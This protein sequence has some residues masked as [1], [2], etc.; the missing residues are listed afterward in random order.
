MGSTCPP[1][2]ESIR[3]FLV[4]EHALV[5]AGLRMLIESGP[6]MMVIGEAGNCAD[7]LPIVVAEQPDI[8]LLEADF[9]DQSD[10]DSV[11]K[12]ITAAKATRV[13]ILSSEQHPEMHQRA[14]QVG[15]TGLVLKDTM[16]GVLFKAIERVNAG[17]VWF[18]RALMA[19][20]LSKLSQQNGAK[21]KDV[22]QV[23]IA[24]LTQREHEVVA[25]V[26]EGLKNKQ[27]AERLFIS[28]TTVHH[29]LTSIFAKLG[30]S[31]RLELV[32]YAYQQGMVKLLKRNGDQ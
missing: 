18:E 13:I 30:V 7:A 6:A 25:L 27:I 9:G 19:D 28:D 23:R 15:A 21:G 14:M 16:P 32:I 17:E 29:H 10:L 24:T 26:G 22:E 8:V 31:D 2:A 11:P 4:A 3:L 5:R 1:T 20:A 12:L